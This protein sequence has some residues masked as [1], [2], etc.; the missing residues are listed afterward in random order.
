MHSTDLSAVAMALDC[1]RHTD[2]K[3]SGY[4]RAKQPPTKI[5]LKPADNQSVRGQQAWPGG[6]GASG[7]DNYDAAGNAVVWVRSDGAKTVRTNVL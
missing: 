1:N 2:V 3:R 5:A 6:A 7:R 4:A